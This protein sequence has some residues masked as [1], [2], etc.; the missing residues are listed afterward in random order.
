MNYCRNLRYSAVTVTIFLIGATFACDAWA[1]DEVTFNFNPPDDTRFVETLRHT[2]TITAEGLIEP[3]VETIES[4]VKCVIRKTDFGCSVTITPPEPSIKASEDMSGMLTSMLSNMVLTF[5][6]DAQGRLLRVRGTEVVTEMM[7]QILS[8]DMMDL[9]LIIYGQSGKSFEEIAEQSA[10]DN[11]NNR[12]MLGIFVGK[13]FVLNKTYS[14]TGKLPIPTGGSIHASTELEISGPRPYKGQQCVSIYVSTESNDPE[15]G[16]K[17]SGMMKN[18]FAGVLTKIEPPKADELAKLI[19]D[20][21]MSTPKVTNKTTRL[22]DPTTGL[23]YLEIQ[24]NIIQAII[25]IDGKEQ[26]KFTVKDKKEYYYTY[27]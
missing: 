2:K 11:W 19:P 24:T 18:L 26:L 3:T 23:I 14:G 8:K 6:L 16:E 25:K 13:T 15:I 9:I 1:K 12:A 5:D 21:Q 7:K 10:V 22:V 4:K 20:F 17:I 27:E